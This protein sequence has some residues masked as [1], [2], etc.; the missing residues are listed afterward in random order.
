[1]AISEQNGKELLSLIADLYQT[2]NPQKLTKIAKFLEVNKRDPK[3]CEEIKRN[4]STIINT[5][6]FHTRHAADIPVAKLW[7]LWEIEENRDANNYLQWL[8]EEVF[9]DIIE[10][11]PIYRI[12]KSLLECG[13]DINA[14][15]NLKETPLHVTI[16]YSSPLLGF[17]LEHGADVNAQDDDGN[18]PLHV[19]LSIKNLDAIR[20][21]ML[22]KD[23]DM[24]LP[25]K[26][27]VSPWQLGKRT[28]LLSSNR[29]VIYRTLGNNSQS[30]AEEGAPIQSRKRPG[31]H[32]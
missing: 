7:P 12:L 11:I 17:L 27:G 3:F 24:N 25:N 16:F 9:T 15:N 19:A 14:R 1:M 22:K 21:L 10:L 4:S 30:F 6:I 32:H 20:L 18:T 23:V 28:C 31:S 2:E 29:Y 13:V 8:P 5:L 26:S